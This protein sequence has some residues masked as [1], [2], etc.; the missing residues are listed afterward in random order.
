MARTSKDLEIVGADAPENTTVANA[1][2]YKGFTFKDRK[3]FTWIHRGPHAAAS[4]TLS[5][6]L[7]YL[8]RAQRLGAEY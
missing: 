7:Y 4:P 6:K 3:G 2:A 1:A 8:S 5:M